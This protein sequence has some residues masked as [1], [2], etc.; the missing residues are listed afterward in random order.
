MQ[1]VSSF[2]YD[3]L[4]A[5]RDRSAPQ[6]LQCVGNFT[7][8]LGEEVD[9]GLLGVQGRI[10]TGCAARGR[11]WMPRA[12]QGD[13][14]GLPAGLAFEGRRGTSWNREFFQNGSGVNPAASIRSSW[15]MTVVAG[16]FT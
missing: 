16:A 4:L 9:A 13:R 1:Q 6:R 15:V 5:V 3:M 14:Y 2:M 11:R 12:R 7:G 10:R 8:N